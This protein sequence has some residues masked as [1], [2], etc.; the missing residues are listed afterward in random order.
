MNNKRNILILIT[1][2]LLGVILPL[3]SLGIG[4]MT[5][6]I[7]F[8][9]VLRGQ[10]VEE[11]L[12]VLNTEN[13]PIVY[14]LIAEGEI[15]GW[16]KFY[17]END[18]DLKNPIQEVTVPPNSKYKLIAAF[19]VPEDTPNGTYTGE[20]AISSSPGQ[21]SDQGI[22]VSVAQRVGRKVS[23]TVTDKE[24]LDFNASIIPNKYALASGDPLIIKAIYRNNGNV[25]IK[26]DIH[27]KIVRIETGETVH[28]A[29][30]PYPEEEE[31]VKPYSR[32]VFDELIKW[33]TAGQP[34]GRYRAEIKVLLNGKTYFEKSF[35]F[36]VGID[37]MELLLASIGK[38]GGG[39]ILL[40]WFVLGA[41]FLSLA[42]ILTIFTQNKKIGEKIKILF[43]NFKINRYL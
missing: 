40:G 37:I 39:N 1:V 4:M 30:Y 12:I 8:E 23:I 13:A 20:V 19:T 36:R 22:T 3:R 34:K 9:N 32:K 26:P 21:K 43:K 42:A 18:K 15:K 2:F 7:V 29:I 33:Q 41:I 35:R 31:A 11:D 25:L 38:L 5:K 6:P 16:A 24:I 27:L 28:N 17:E 14:K 10:T